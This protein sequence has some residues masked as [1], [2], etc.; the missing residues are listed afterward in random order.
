MEVRPRSSGDVGA[1]V[2]LGDLVQRHDGY[3]VNLSTDVATFL[4]TPDALA[5]WVAEVDG[6]VVGHVALHSHT[7]PDLMDRA[8]TALGCAADEL[9]VVARLLVDPDHRHAGVGRALLER[10]AHEA[11]QR[12]RHPILDVSSRFTTA[13]AL[14]ERCGW[15]RC[16]SVSFEHQGVT[17]D[18]IL[19]L[20]PTSFSAPD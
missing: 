13:I 18:E 15:R 10:A 5:A 20:G 2:A 11:R 12:Q 14:Y 4:I 1:C 6:E 9:G 19:Y 7:L 17:L 8:T 16:G 3:P